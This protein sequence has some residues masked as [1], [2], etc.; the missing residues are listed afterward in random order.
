M[1]TGW[2]IWTGAL[3]WMETG[4]VGVVGMGVPQGELVFSKSCGE[5]IWVNANSISVVRILVIFFL[6]DQMVQE[7][8]N[9]RIFG[10]LHRGWCRWVRPLPESRSLSELFQHL[11]VS[12][13]VDGRQ[14]RWGQGQVLVLGVECHVTLF[15]VCLPYFLDCRLGKVRVAKESLREAAPDVRQFEAIEGCVQR[16]RSVVCDSVRSVWNSEFFKFPPS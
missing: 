9:C 2:T 4:H 5:S 13:V 7:D 14:H 8:C 3:W 16:L 10:C 1:G 12:F 6:P 11:T 15:E